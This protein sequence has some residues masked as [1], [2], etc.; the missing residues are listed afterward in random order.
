LWAVS[1]FVAGS[2]LNI[3]G[4]YFVSVI[5]VDVVRNCRLIH[6][7]CITTSIPWCL[8]FTSLLIYCNNIA[9]SQSGPLKWLVF[10]S[11]VPQ[12]VAEKHFSDQQM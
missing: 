9:Q 2:E 1:H 7:Q 11:A 5:M 4:T 3:S 6:V 10:D 8:I 12:L